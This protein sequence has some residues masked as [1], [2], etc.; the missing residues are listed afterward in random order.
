MQ[1]N[2]DLVLN[3]ITS[4]MIALDDYI[5][6]KINDNVNSNNTGIFEYSARLVSE[7]LNK[8]SKEVT[9]CE[10]RISIIQ[11]FHDNKGR[12]HCSMIS[13]K[14][15]KRTSCLKKDI[16]IRYTDNSYYYL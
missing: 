8:V 3:E 10:V 16:P 14:S 9:G 6:D 5:N 15:K 11:Q 13:R 7:S 4:S 12:R 1:R 2:A